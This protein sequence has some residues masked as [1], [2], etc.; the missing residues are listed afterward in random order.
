MVQVQPLQFQFQKSCSLGNRKPR[1]KFRTRQRIAANKRERSRM[2]TI[3][4]GFERLRQVVPYARDDRRHSKVETLRLAIEYIRKGLEILL[5]LPLVGVQ[6]ESILSLA[7][8]S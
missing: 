7:Q 2:K 4:K 3:N 8:K 1:L 5:K 6:I